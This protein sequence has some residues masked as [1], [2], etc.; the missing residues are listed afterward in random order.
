MSLRPHLAR[1]CELVTVVTVVTVVTLVAAPSLAW[2][3]DATAR[4]HFRRGVDLYDKKQYQPA[5]DAFR[6]AYAEKP[7]P[8]IK[9]NIAL[10]LKGLGRPIEAATAFD[11]ALDE[12]ADLLKPEVK[13]A[14]EHE[15]AD[16]SKVVAT[17]RL[18]VVT[19][20]DK[21]PIDGAVVTVDG[22]VLPAAALRRPV[23]LEPGIHVFTARAV[24]MPDPPEKKLSLLVGA[25]VDATFELG[26]PVGQLTIKPSVADAEVQVDGAVVGRGEWSGK[27]T[28]GNHRVTVVSP[29]FQTTTAEVVITS[30]ASVEYPITLL[31]AVEPPPGYELPVRKPPPRIK[32]GYIV[33][34]IAYEGQSLRVAPILG[35]SAGGTKR[36][37]TGAAAGV[38]IG[39]RATR[40][41]ALELH[42]EVGQLSD[43]YKIGNASNESTIKVLHWQLTPL[44]RFTTLGTVRFTG[45]TGV[46]LHGLS[47]NA[48]IDTG[49]AT[50]SLS[51]TKKGSGVAFSWL[52]DLGMQIDVGS[53]F[54]E[55]AVFLDMHGV[56]TTRENA[57]NERMFLSS[58][59]T[60]AGLRVGLGIP[61]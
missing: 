42:G 29:G 9:Q 55:G 17:V 26:R 35:E 45:A 61:F 23:R 57:S 8:G 11:E 7:S 51:T 27:L 21:K 31:R 4:E 53:L 37:L 52:L 25:P 18:Q 6:A 34:M 15:L 56:G 59:S 47:V 48:E 16:L 30:G 28:V 33:P 1:L 49:T 60:R 20:A 22:A 5:L 32:K 54:L 43:E 2:A 19:A 13:A 14:M 10:S 58:P 40:V 46:G 38:R 50:T 12:G 39:Y 36:P 41:V 3:D 44:V 24:G